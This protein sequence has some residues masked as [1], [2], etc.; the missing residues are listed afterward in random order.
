MMTVTI[1]K[2]K[3]SD[4]DEL[5][6]LWNEFIIT[7]NAILVRKNPELKPYLALKKDFLKLIK[8]WLVKTIRSRNSLVT[9]VE[10]KNRIVGVCVTKINK[11]NPIM[12]LEKLGYIN[13]IYVKKEYRGTGISSKFKNEALTWLK[14]KGIKHISL[15]VDFS[16]EHARKVYKNW[17][18]IDYSIDKRR[19]I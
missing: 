3:L 1:R 4:L 7:S 5:V 13:D 18:F 16:N 6:N 14:N 8:K 19:K 15:S 2:A 9:L 17:G 12:R 11:N 10:D